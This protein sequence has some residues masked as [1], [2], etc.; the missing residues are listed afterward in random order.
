MASNRK[1]LISGLLLVMILC[2]MG[3]VYVATFHME[4]LQGVVRDLV[5]SSF[6][7][8]V[9]V[10]DVQ[11]KFFPYPHV[12]LMDVSLIEPGQ[13]TPI[14]QASRIQL[15]LS[16]L[17]LI[18][19]R[20][21]PNALLI[22]NAFLALER[23][24][25]GQWNY[26]NIFQ[27]EPDGKAGLGAWLWGRSL[28]VSNG[29][30]HLVDRY[31]RKSPFI[32]QT[33]K[34]GLHVERLVLD[35]PTDVALSARLRDTGSILSFSGTL[36]NIGGWSGSM[37][38][39]HAAPQ[40]DLYADM[41]LEPKGLLQLTDLFEIGKVPV[42]WQGRTKAQGQ[43]HFAPGPEGYDLSLSDLV[44]LTDSIDLNAQVKMTGLLR[45]EPP[46]FSGQWTSAPIA[47]QHL[48][49]LLPEG[50]VSSE[51]DDAIR[52][53]TISGEI[54][55]ISATLTGSARKDVGYSLTGKF[56]YSEGVVRF[57]PEWGKI[58]EMACA[59]HVQAD[60][61]QLSDFRG[62]Y[63]QIP[64]THGVGTIDFTEQG[65]W[66]TTELGGRVPSKKMVD[67]MQPVLGWDASLDT[68]QSLQGQA[69]SGLLTVRFAGSLGNAQAVTFQ[70]A[71][72][73]A[74]RITVQLPGVQGP[75]TQVEGLLAFS[76]KHLRFENVR[77]LYGQSDFQIEGKLKFEKQLHLEDVSIQ[78]H[79]SDSDLFK[80]FPKQAP[81]AQKIISGKTDYL[82][83]VNGKQHNYTMRGRVALQGL[84]ILLPGI[85]SKR[86]TLA[87]NLD[88]HVEVGKHH[89]VVFKRLVMTLPSVHLAGQGEF[90]FNQTS[91]FNASLMAEPI[92]F[93]SLP[94]ELELFEK[95]IASGTLQGF[96]KLRG[97]GGDW[98]AWHKSGW[99]ALTNGV[100]NVESLKSPISEVMLQVKMS[101]HGA[102]L[103]QLRW[104]F[105]GS[106]AQAT[107]IIR[108]WD[109]QP[110]ANFALVS[111]HFNVDLLLSR[112]QP[113][114][115][116]E[117]LEKI[118]Q[119]AEVAGTLR[120]DRALYRNLTLQQ[121]TGQVQ[122][123]N[124]IILVEQIRGE[125]DKGTIQGRVSVH[126]PVRQPAT[127]KTWFKVNSLPMLTLQRT[128]FDEATLEKDKRLI[129]GLL[130][131]EGALQGHGNDPGGVLPT[132][133]GTLKFSIV[134]GRIKRGIIIPKILSLMN[135]P[136]MLQGTVD[137][138]TDGY[139]FDRQAGTVRIADGRIVSQDIVMDG[140]ILKMTA[141]GQYDLVHDD[142]DV[143]T[144]A[145]PLGPYFE[146][147][148]KIPILHLLLDGE[149]RGVDLAMFSVKGSLHAP[150]IEPMAVESVT[151][152]VTGFAKL[153]LSILKNTLT[154]PQ[155]I[156]FPEDTDSQEHPPPEQ[157]SEDT[158][159]ESY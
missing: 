95:T 31:R 68:I 34:V 41:D 52:L 109:G 158:S 14:F 64:V 9:L 24:E 90:H 108:T 117:F 99:V 146:L 94:P 46:M 149:E 111:P 159:M 38:E 30:I 137:L 86:P 106:R 142:L 50:F 35:G 152:G 56:Q 5:A 51:L 132:L 135:L 16:F 18:Q 124:G 80:L 148:Q 153:A 44:V 71:E 119:T 70:G 15:D 69:G 98:K 81:S 49:Q 36:Q 59:I 21:M 97:R 138:E 33:D 91:T 22:E 28:K 58:E 154:L 47:I 110:K 1:R 126:L 114:L 8:H 67:I 48:P 89:R 25:Q 143:V 120:F 125:A 57:G 103:K 101:G 3:V 6:G 26:R 131:A 76:P 12:N 92:N 150:T 7:E 78:G 11:V 113:S 102:E 140:P 134:D 45:P 32:L 112:E 39:S 151:S 127:V 88:F 62:Q 121:L 155:K 82:V 53:H 96:I 100:I 63:E 10:K 133:K 4:D 40:L 23:N 75:L 54:Q 130:S 72:Y 13:G 85:L 129:T 19:E 141:A 123:K 37:V 83:M 156:F 105:E 66:L 79:V 136:G 93:E 107:G 144:V 60:Q 104:N 61:I 74:E 17:S 87:G 116:R 145:S 147:L 84:E 139:P 20:P 77:G 73:H 2:V 157:D 128:F 65:P 122:I 43:I 42:G 115:L 27:Q 118:T 55:A 29:S